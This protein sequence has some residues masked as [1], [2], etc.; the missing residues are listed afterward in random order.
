V[1][2]LC[3]KDSSHVS[4]AQKN[5]INGTSEAGRA[6]LGPFVESN[7]L[8]S[9]ARPPE[10]WT[11]VALT[12]KDILELDLAARLMC[13]LSG[14]R[15]GRGTDSACGRDACSVHSAVSDLYHTMSGVA[16]RGVR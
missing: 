7:T 11:P 1:R 15:E 5:V 6:H 2:G 9:D 14:P 16:D 13:T 12:A 10:A 3:G 8:A 4:A